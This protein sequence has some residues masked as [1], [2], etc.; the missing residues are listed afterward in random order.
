MDVCPANAGEKFANE[1]DLAK[2]L[3]M[4]SLFDE[5]DSGD[6]VVVEGLTKSISRNVPHRPCRAKKN[7]SDS[8]D[9]DMGTR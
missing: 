3:V 1:V 5:R 6:F 9:H 7:A 2:P 4:T 8:A